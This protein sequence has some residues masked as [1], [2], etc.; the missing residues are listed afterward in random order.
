MKTKFVSLDDLKFQTHPA[1]K[2][3]RALELQTIY[4]QTKNMKFKQPSM[5]LGGGDGYLTS[6]LFD[7]T[8]TYN[9]DNGEA[10]DV[11]VS[12]Q[13]KRY[14]KVLIESAEK[15]SI[16][17]NS[18]NFIFSNSVIEHIPDNEAVLREVARTLKKGGVF[19]F[20]SPSDKFKE[21]LWIPDILKKIG[22]EFLIEPYKN[23]RNQMLNHYHT[24]SHKTWTKKLK[25][26]GLVVKKY[27]YYIEKENGKLWDKI[28][29]QTK[30]RALFDKQADNHVYN[31]HKELI[32]ARYKSDTVKG[33]CGASLFIYAVKK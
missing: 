1:A 3:F 27:A 8:F 4:Q 7:D 17:S 22:L 24:Y 32:A 2:L 12:I 14:K 9:V 31:K 20:T 13:K 23:K 16:K 25:K 19:I 28:A 18:L 11:H 6:L 5:D 26:H 33:D 30:F 29:W 21:Y 15:T 10:K